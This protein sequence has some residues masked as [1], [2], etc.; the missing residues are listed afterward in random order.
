VTSSGPWFHISLLRADSRAPI[1]PLRWQG[2]AAIAAVFATFAGPSVL[3]DWFGWRIPLLFALV[4]YLPMALF[5]VTLILIKSDWN[6][7]SG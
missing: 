4:W 1:Y 5:W 7:S 3:H 6:R 2:W